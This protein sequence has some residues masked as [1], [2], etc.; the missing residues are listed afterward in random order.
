MTPTVNSIMEEI[1]SLPRKKQKD[2]YNKLLS[3]RLGE[4]EGDGSATLA[5]DR[6]EQL[7]QLMLEMTGEDIANRTRIME[8]IIPRFCTIAQMRDEGYTFM[9]ISRACGFSNAAIHHAMRCI[10]NVLEYPSMNQKFVRTYRQMK[11]L[12][13]EKQVE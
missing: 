9:E 3:M 12:L 7:R 8:V 2:I 5:K 13:N 10:E 1:R 6:W 11:R 4:I